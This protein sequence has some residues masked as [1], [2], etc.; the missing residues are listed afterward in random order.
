MKT[1]IA[2]KAM[3]LGA[4]RGGL[5]E[6]SID[7]NF[8]LVNCWENSFSFLIE[9]LYEYRSKRHRLQLFKKKIEEK[10]FSEK[11]RRGLWEIHKN[12]FPAAFVYYTF[13]ACL[14]FSLT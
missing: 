12:L 4:G 7:P 9:I 6:N 2:C 13:Q 11:V 10:I 1:K 14:M 5:S 8:S 3:G